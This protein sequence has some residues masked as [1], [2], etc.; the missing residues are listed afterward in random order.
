VKE[1]PSTANIVVT[2]AEGG[3]QQ[4]QQQQPAVAVTV[5]EE[6]FEVDKEAD[7]KIEVNFARNKINL[8]NN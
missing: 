8:S 3:G 7:Q 4:A 1:E 5:K 6:A 2:P